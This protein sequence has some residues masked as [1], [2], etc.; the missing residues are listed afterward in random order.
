MEIVSIKPLGKNR[1]RVTREDGLTLA[2]YKGEFSDFG[3][4]EGANLTDETVDIIVKS[5]LCKRAESRIL[6]A[7]QKKD[8]TEKQLRDKL[9]EAY[10]LE[11]AIEYAIEKVKSYGY[12]DD[13]RY[14]R[15][16]IRTHID[17]KSH[18]EIK[19]VLKQ[20]GISDEVLTEAFLRNEEEGYVS[21]EVSLIQKYLVKRHYDP[22][23]SDYKEKAKQYAYLVGKGF[24]GE[25]I[26]KAL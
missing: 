23:T 20:R 14:A 11:P 2:L 25:D 18:F 13:A 16:Y 3:I 24:R 7:L 6:F 4:R 5:I 8:Y 19:R 15:N 9:H 21:D 12:L 17:C 1:Y 26:K 10:Y 22:A